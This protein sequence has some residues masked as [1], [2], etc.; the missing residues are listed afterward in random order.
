MERW[1]RLPIWTV[2]VVALSA[3]LMLACSP[4]AQPSPKAAE[5][6]STKPAEAKPAAAGPSTMTIEELYE[7]AKA[8]GGALQ[9]YCTMAQV[10]AVKFFPAF[11][12]RFAGIKAEQIDATADKLVARIT[13]EARGGKTLADTFQGGMDYA[14]HPN[15]RV[16]FE[17]ASFRFF[18]AGSGTTRLGRFTV[19]V[20]RDA[21][22]FWTMMFGA[23]A[24]F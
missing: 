12:Q 23:H 16:F 21:A 22:S 8:E 18:T 20:E 11:E 4:A 13:A 3:L 17:P 7:K 15:L 9:C 10:N 6:P 19:D 24:T 14:V 1:K 5:A 2:R